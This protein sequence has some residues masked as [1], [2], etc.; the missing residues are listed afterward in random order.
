[1]AVSRLLLLWL[2]L[3]A[4]LAGANHCQFEAAGLIEGDHGE[5]QSA[6]CNASEGCARDACDVVESGSYRT[7][8]ESPSLQAPADLPADLLLTLL[9]S[10]ARP[11]A[12]TSP[13]PRA[14]DREAG[15]LTPSW[16][17]VLRHAGQPRA[18]SIL[19]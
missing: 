2:S 1:M 8:D 4:W 9:A 11:S 12:S 16:H 10:L 6:C 14:W 3:A 17:F 18:P 7:S 15:N 5:A 13:L 19:S